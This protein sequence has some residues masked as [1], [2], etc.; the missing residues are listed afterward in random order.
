[1]ASLLK[2]KAPRPGDR[3]SFYGSQTGILAD[4]TV[5]DRPHHA[6]DPSAELQ[7]PDADNYPYIVDL[8]KANLYDAPVELT[9]EIRERL[10]AFE[11]SDASE[12]W[13]WFVLTVRQLSRKDFRILTGKA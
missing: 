6:E 3:I 1:M 11:N 12:G 7:I 4:A 10:E 2:P 9:E 8:E 5:A 13:G